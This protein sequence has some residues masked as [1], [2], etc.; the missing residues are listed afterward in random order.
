MGCQEFECCVERRL[1][2]LEVTDENR[3]LRDLTEKAEQA[4]RDQ[5]QREIASVKAAFPPNVVW[6][7]RTALLSRLA[8]EGGS[9]SLDALNKNLQSLGRDIWELAGVVPWNDDTLLIFKQRHL[10]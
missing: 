5:V 8:G 1:Y 6:V 2:A 10:E 9:S 7:Y 4:A 3:H